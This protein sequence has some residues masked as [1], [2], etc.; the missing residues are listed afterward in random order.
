[1]PNSVYE[2]LRKT[3]SELINCDE[4]EV[5][6]EAKLVD[7][8][9]FESID[10]LELSMILSKQ[11]RLAVDDKALFLVDFRLLAAKGENGARL[12][13]LRVAYP[14]LSEE[15]LKEMLDL[16]PRKSA[17]KVNH[18]VRYIAYHADKA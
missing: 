15:E 4:D 5:T 3:I 10:F 16:P 6:P 7:D 1:M 2:T 9:G 8:L 18:L 12:E 13:H 14:H 17:L 11:H